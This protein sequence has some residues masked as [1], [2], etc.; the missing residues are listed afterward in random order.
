MSLQ[1]PWLGKGIDDEGNIR[2]EPK[3]EQIEVVLAAENGGHG[4]SEKF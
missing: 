1:K 2:N 4:R 3:K